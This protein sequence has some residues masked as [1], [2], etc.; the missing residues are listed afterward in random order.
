[1][2]AVEFKQT[3]KRV[4]SLSE[5]VM[6][7]ILGLLFLLM[8]TIIVMSFVAVANKTSNIFSTNIIKNYIFILLTAVILVV[9]DLAIQKGKLQAKEWLF[10]AIYLM[11]FVLLNVFN[12]FNLYRFFAFNFLSNFILGAFYTLLGVSIYYNYL[13]NENNKV[14]AKAVMVIVFAFALTIAC[15]FVM[16]LVKWLV[17]LAFASAVL[18]FADV[19]L[20]IVYAMAGSVVLNFVFYLSLLKKKQIINACLID[21]ERGD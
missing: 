6:F 8:T 19:V 5:I 21:V 1:M 18:T 16:E 11:I 10:T 9:V 3:K 2:K 17:S 7:T 12:I 4:L 15:S 13:K 14:K 20:N